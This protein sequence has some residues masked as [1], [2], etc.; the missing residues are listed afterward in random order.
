MQ[1]VIDNTLAY[2][3]ANGVLRSAELAV[4]GV[5]GVEVFAFAF[6]VC[7]PQTPFQCLP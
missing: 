5:P 3:G 6:P 1:Q 2:A 7:L 4:D